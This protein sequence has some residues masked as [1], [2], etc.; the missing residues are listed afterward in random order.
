MI[1][2]KIKVSD[3]PNLVSLADQFVAGDKLD[4]QIIWLELKDQCEGKEFT[5]Y[6]FFDTFC[7]LNKIGPYKDTGKKKKRSFQKKI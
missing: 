5:A 4:K 3:Y 2:R 7:E 1:K 6:S